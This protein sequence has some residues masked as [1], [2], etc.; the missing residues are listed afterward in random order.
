[1]NI[2]RNNYELFFIDFYDGNLTDAQKHELDLFLE[3]NSDLKE[4]LFNLRFQ[5]EIGQL[6]N[7]QRMKLTKREIA[8][9]KTII[10]EVAINQQKDK[11]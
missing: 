5:H 4:E 2:N 3:E 9:L 11:E 6:E 8:R 7:P 10:G 1:M